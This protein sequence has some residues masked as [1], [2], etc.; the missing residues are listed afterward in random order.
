MG[1]QRRGGVHRSPGRHDDYRVSGAWTARH[2]QDSSGSW[3]PLAPCSYTPTQARTCAAG[4]VV[5][6]LHPLADRNAAVDIG[7]A[8]LAAHGRGRQRQ[9]AAVALCEQVSDAGRCVRGRCALAALWQR[10]DFTRHAG[11]EMVGRLSARA[12]SAAPTFLGQLVHVLPC[13]LAPTDNASRA[14]A[15]AS[16]RRHVG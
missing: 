6:D 10:R 11:V 7:E 3:N 13:A 2:H 4:L 8:V 9:A 5:G 14:A 16:R 15:S 1:L 12:A